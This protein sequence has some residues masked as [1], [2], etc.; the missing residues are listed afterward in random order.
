M[1]NFRKTA[2]WARIPGLPIEFYNKHFLWRIGNRIGKSLKVDTN[3]LSRK[4][5]DGDDI[6]EKAKFTLYLC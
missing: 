5:D 2:I 4:K 3:T 6:M 1:D